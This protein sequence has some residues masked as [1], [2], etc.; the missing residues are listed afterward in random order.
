[1]QKVLKHCCDKTV[2]DMRSDCTREISEEN[3]LKAAH[4]DMS[5]HT[6]AF[7]KSVL[8]EHS[9][10]GWDPKVEGNEQV[11]DIA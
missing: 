9:C 4:S 7:L 10:L 5:A 1:V 6:L 2:A 11:E 3:P 8:L